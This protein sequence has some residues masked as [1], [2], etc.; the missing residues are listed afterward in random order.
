MFKPIGE[1]VKAGCFG[2]PKFNLFTGDYAG[3]FPASFYPGLRENSHHWPLRLPRIRERRIQPPTPR[4][5]CVLQKAT[6]PMG[7][8]YSP[9]WYFT[10]FLFISFPF[11]FS[12]SIQTLLLFN[13]GKGALL[14]VRN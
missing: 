13:F 1:I 9:S 4:T 8:A 12:L 3:R 5:V 7:I 11:S 2:F 10:L 14:L 6:S